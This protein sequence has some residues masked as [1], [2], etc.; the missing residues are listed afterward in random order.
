MIALKFVFAGPSNKFND[1]DLCDERKL[2]LDEWPWIG[3]PN[4]YETDL[5]C[6]N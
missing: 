4:T 3:K 6:E 5:V 2:V 1:K